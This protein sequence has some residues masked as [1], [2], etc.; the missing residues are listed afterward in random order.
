MAWLAENRQYEA[1][2]AGAMEK[3]KKVYPR[4]GR[5]DWKSYLL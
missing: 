4:A 2:G 1:G 5:E 3:I